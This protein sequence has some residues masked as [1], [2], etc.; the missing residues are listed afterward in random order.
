MAES[1]TKDAPARKNDPNKMAARVAFDPTVPSEKPQDYYDT[2]KQ[3]FAEERD[4]RLK[5]RPEGLSQYTSELEGDLAKYEVDPYA[6]EQTEREPI[7][8][9]V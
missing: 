9:H 4:V 3:R 8:D 5:Y 1:G 2:I 7:S 6:E